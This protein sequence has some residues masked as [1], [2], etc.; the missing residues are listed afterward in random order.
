MI[1]NFQLKVLQHG[2]LQTN[3]NWLNTTDNFLQSQ[4][5]M[6]DPGLRKCWRL[7]ADD[8]MIKLQLQSALRFSGCTAC[9]Y[10]RT[11]TDWYDTWKK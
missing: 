4:T 7:N 6:K 2:T 8:E 5:E 10:S 11:C 9:R 1:C 3:P